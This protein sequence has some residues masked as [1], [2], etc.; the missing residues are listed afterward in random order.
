MSNVT[1]YYPIEE[2]RLKFNHA[3]FH[4]LTLTGSVCHFVM[5]YEYVLAT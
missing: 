4:I 2:E 3:L 5:I 1:R